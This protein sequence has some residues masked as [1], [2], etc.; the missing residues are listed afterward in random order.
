MICQ[1]NEVE[2]L[3][4]HVRNDHINLLVSVLLHLSVSKLVQ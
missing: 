3:A 2:I 1:N 4:R